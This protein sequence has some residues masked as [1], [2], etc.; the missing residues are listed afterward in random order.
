MY[1]SAIAVYM[2]KLY[3]RIKVNGKWTWKPATVV[4]IHLNDD[5]DG[6]DPYETYEVEALRGE[7]E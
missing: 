5:E 4:T 6:T 1:T 7:N 2:A 3:W